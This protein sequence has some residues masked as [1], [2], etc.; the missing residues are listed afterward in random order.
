MSLYL[1]I[2][3]FF[4]FGVLANYHFGLSDSLKNT[5]TL[6]ANQWIIYVALTSIIFLKVP[7][8]EFSFNALVPSAVAWG[9]LVFSA[10]LVLWLS[11]KLKAKASQRYLWC[12]VVIGAFR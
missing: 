5:V 10:V 12:Y 7:K 6:R 4:A 2:A 11:R 9:W 1:I 8:L 3:F